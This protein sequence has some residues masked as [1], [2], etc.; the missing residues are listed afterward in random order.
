VPVAEQLRTVQ[1]PIAAFQLLERQ[2]AQV[3]H[4]L[5]T[6]APTPPTNGC[7]CLKRDPSEAQEP[8]QHAFYLPRKG[9]AMPTLTLEPLTILAPSPLSETT[10][11]SD[12]Q[13]G[14]GCGCEVSLTQLT[15]PPDAAEHGGNATSA[16]PTQP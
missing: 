4:R 3:L 1:Q 8:C 11:V 15:L 14:C 13:C 16:Q 6:G 10:T 5:Q 7:Q 9:Q 12:A 2:L